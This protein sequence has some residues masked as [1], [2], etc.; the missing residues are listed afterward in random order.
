MVAMGVAMPRAGRSAAAPLP[1]DPHR[2]RLTA[3]AGSRPRSV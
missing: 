2:R 1:H 3:P